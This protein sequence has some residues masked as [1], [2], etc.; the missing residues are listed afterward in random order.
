MNLQSTVTTTPP[1][2]HTFSLQ[3]QNLP[4]L[5]EFQSQSFEQKNQT[6]PIGAAFTTNLKS[7]VKKKKSQIK[8]QSRFCLKYEFWKLCRVQQ[9]GIISALTFDSLGICRGG[10]LVKYG[11]FWKMVVR[12]LQKCSVF[13]I[14]WH[15]WFVRWYYGVCKEFVRQSWQLYYC[16]ILNFATF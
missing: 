15:C 11:P 1:L 10:F 2:V 4:L 8:S 6:M 13:L 14:M 7:K 9:L 12:H 3:F 16:H 5:L